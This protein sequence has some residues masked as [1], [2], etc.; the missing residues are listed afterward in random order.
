[1]GRLTCIGYLRPE[2]AHNEREKDLHARH[3]AKTLA[4]GAA[5]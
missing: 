3:E 4:A 5:G 2:A 1:M